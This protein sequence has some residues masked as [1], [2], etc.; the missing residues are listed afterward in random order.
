MRVLATS[1]PDVRVCRSEEPRLRFSRVSPREDARAA[2]NRTMAAVPRRIA[3]KVLRHVRNYSPRG[4]R[5]SS[6]SPKPEQNPSN[7]GGNR[8]SVRT[9]YLSG[10][11]PSTV[12]SRRSRATHPRE[13]LADTETRDGVRGDR[14]LL[15]LPTPGV[16]VIGNR[17]GFRVRVANGARACTASE[18]TTALERSRWRGRRYA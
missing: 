4:P 14:A 12:T 9:G 15:D 2:G 11:S 1:S 6:D 16:G 17:W 18:P 8:G 13:P 10:T 7:Q 5:Q 3:L